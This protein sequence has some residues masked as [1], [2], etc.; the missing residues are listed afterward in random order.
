MSESITTLAALRES[1]ARLTPD[2]DPKSRKKPHLRTTGYAPFDQALNGGFVGGRLHE[3]YTDDPLNAS[4]AAAFAA[5][6][7]LRNA[8]IEQPLIWLRS[9]DA[10]RQS[11]RIY[12]PGLMQ[13]GGN[14]DQLLLVE[15]DGPKAFLAA[16]HDAARCAGSAAV[17]LESWGALPHLDLTASRRLALAARHS[18]TL[19][20]LL[21]LAA[22]LSPSVAETRWR[23]GPAASHMLEAN[24]PGVPA[25][26]LE[27]LRWRA[28][29]AGSHWQMK[30]NVEEKSF[31]A[32]ALSGPVLSMAAN[33]PLMPDR[34]AAA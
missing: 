5:L 8:T 23:I 19:L 27:L 6:L 20:L 14:P 18:N 34:A 29:A 4:T 30:W 25:F 3:F 22:P 31:E 11:G 7:A 15:A 16:A 1:V 32:A 10:K 26:D 12:A 28:G 33:G 21:R 17:I 24:A 9:H 2:G 13:L